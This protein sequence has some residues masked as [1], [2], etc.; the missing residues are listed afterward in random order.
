MEATTWAMPTRTNGKPGGACN[1]ASRNRRRQ[2]RTQRGQG[3]SGTT[4]HSLISL[5]EK[6]VEIKNKLQDLPTR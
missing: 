2:P 3:V 6:T 4:G 1:R 5:A